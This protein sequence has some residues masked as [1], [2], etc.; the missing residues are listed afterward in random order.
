MS[1]DLSLED[2]FGDEPE[3]SAA[4]LAALSSAVED[5]VALETRMSDLESEIK[6]VS[7]ALNLIKAKRI[8]DLMASVGMEEGKFHGWSVKIKAVVSGSLPKDPAARRTALDW[9]R[10]N[11]GSELI[12]TEIKMAFGPGSDNVAA[13]LYDDLLREGH[14]ATLDNGVNPQSLAAFARERIRHGEEVDADV[15]GLY[16]A[17]VAKLEKSK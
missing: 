3:G 8:P 15:L 6:A 14:N 11:G 7:A 13:A 1:N 10:D 12:R 5:A 17:R 9:L 16:I 2:F 4:D